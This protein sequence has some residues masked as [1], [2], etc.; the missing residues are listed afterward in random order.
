[1]LRSEAHLRSATEEDPHIGKVGTG[2]ICLEN[3][4]RIPPAPAPKL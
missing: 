3:G 4:A 2:P 1:M